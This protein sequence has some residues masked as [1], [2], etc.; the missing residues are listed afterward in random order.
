MKDTE[1]NENPNHIVVFTT[2]IT[3]KRHASRMYKNYYISL[4]IQKENKNTRH[5]KEDNF[6][7]EKN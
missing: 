6:I 7:K 3:N 5:L 1:N 4:R 2:H